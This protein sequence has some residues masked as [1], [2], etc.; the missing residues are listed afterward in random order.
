M[1]TI[2]IKHHR[3]LGTRTYTVY[4]VD[5]A[6][7]EGISFKHWSKCQ[8]GEW[9]ASDDGYVGKCIKRQ[10]SRGG[11]KGIFFTYPYGRAVHPHGKLVIGRDNPWD[12]AGKHRERP[13]ETRTP[14]QRLALVY[15]LIGHRRKAIQ[16]AFPSAD[17]AQTTRLLRATYSTKFKKMADQKTVE[18]LNDTGLTKSHIAKR[19]MKAAD[20]AEENKDVPNLLKTI[21]NMETLHNMLTEV[22]VTAS[23]KQNLIDGVNRNKELPESTGGNPNENQPTTTSVERKVEIKGSP[24]A[25]KAES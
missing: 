7:D 22:T 2:T 3:P 16:I 13:W 17:A 5:E 9:G 20:I 21:E 12:I 19:L 25:I 14:Y 1:H 24:E 10:R 18:I 11:S 8:P 23:E 6:K 15:G 4:T